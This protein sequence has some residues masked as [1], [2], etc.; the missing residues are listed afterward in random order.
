MPCTT[1]WVLVHQLLQVKWLPEVLLTP[2]R[3]LTQSGTPT[4]FVEGL[5]GGDIPNVAQ[6]RG[7]LLGSHLLQASCLAAS[8]HD[9]VVAGLPQSPH[10][11]HMTRLQRW[12]A[13]ASGMKQRL[14]R[15]AQ[16]LA[17]MQH[18]VRLQRCSVAAWVL[19]CLNSARWLACSTVHLWLQVWL[20]IRAQA[21]LSR[22][23]LA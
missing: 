12:N 5:V 8:P 13:A 10:H 4:C 9:G 6:Q 14:S 2:L 21:R 20:H 18:S 19:E 3:C 17:C 16:R 23:G 11:L 22:N 1:G 15:A 7:C